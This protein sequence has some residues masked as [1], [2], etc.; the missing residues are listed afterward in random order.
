MAYEPMYEPTDENV[1]EV[2]GRYLYEWKFFYL[3]AQEMMTRHMSEALVKYVVIKY[4][5]DDKHAGN[6]AT[7]RLHSSIIIHVNNSPIIWY[8]KQQNTVEAS[9]FVSD[10]VAVSITTEMIESPS[11]KLRCFGIPVE[12]PA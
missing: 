11:Y 3:D 2:V 8:S 7:R 9:S 4:Y 12:G 5:V 6:I 1:F 10:F